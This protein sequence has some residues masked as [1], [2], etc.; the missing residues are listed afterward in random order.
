[1]EISPKHGAEVGGVFHQYLPA[2]NGKK[3]KHEEEEVVSNL[4]QGS[5]LPPATITVSN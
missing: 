1:M 3:G 2:K 4:W 5:L